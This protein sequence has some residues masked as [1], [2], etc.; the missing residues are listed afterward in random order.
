MCVTALTTDDLTLHTQPQTS[1]VS[2]AQQHVTRMDQTPC[3][4][5]FL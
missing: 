4:V 5:T 1:P 2:Y 3:V